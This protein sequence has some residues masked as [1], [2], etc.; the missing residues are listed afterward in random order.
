M[1]RGQF[2]G[3]HAAQ[4]T[5]VE[6]EVQYAVSLCQVSRARRLGWLTVLHALHFHRPAMLALEMQL[7]AQQWSA[8]SEKKALEEALAKAQSEAS[9]LKSQGERAI[10]AMQASKLVRTNPFHRMLTLSTFPAAK[11]TALTVTFR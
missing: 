2:A 9:A 10:S 7:E 3:S 1:C 6:Q 8:R 5:V 11:I 4:Q